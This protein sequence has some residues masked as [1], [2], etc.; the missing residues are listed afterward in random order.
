MSMLLASAQQRD[1]KKDEEE[2]TVL[3]YARKVQRDKEKQV[4]AAKAL[5]EAKKKRKVLSISATEIEAM[6]RAAGLSSTKQQKQRQPKQRRVAKERKVAKVA[7]ALEDSD[8]DSGTDSGP[9]RRLKV[10]AHTPPVRVGSFEFHLDADWERAKLKGLFSAK[11]CDPVTGLTHLESAKKVDTICSIAFRVSCCQDMLALKRDNYVTANVKITQKEKI[12]RIVVSCLFGVLFGWVKKE[13][14]SVTNLNQLLMEARAKV[15]VSE[16][17]GKKAHY[18]FA[19]ALIEYVKTEICEPS[20]KNVTVIDWEKDIMSYAIATC[21]KDVR[22]VTFTRQTMWSNAFVKKYSA[23]I[24][25]EGWTE[26]CDGIL[27][28]YALLLDRV[29]LGY[30]GKVTDKTNDRFLEYRLRVLAAEDPDD[31]SVT[32]PFLVHYCTPAELDRDNWDHIWALNA[33]QRLYDAK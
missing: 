30:Y 25:K 31:L 3:A 8:S 1:E 2:A 18:Q 16:H 19:I 13:Y 22:C 32:H 24:K 28:E 4:A 9:L 10:V 11:T 29:C 12:K 5:V 6:K 14:K 23:M 33:K 15:G 20:L 7:V 26:C 27:L 17:A 21:L